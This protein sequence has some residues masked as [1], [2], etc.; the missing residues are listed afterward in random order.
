MRDE[1]AS[2]HAGGDRTASERGAVERT[3]GGR[4]DGKRVGGERAG[5]ER[6]SGEPTGVGRAATDPTGS[7]LFDGARAVPVAAL[8]AAGLVLGIIGD[9]LLR[10]P[11]PPGLNMF[12]WVASIALAAYVLHRRAG[13]ELDGE[14]FAWLAITVLFAAGLA[15]RDSPPLKLL[16]LGCAT[17]GFALAAYRVGAAWVRRAGVFLY[18]RAWGT[19]A[20]HAW[21]APAHALLDASRST[22]RPDIGRT[23]GWRQA[24]AVARGFL[25]ATPLVAVFGALFM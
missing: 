22:A 1:E 14:R 20:L 21:T 7:G 10:A 5:S 4:A 13:L 16:A 25:I 8:L 17:L 11:G 23:A 18:V 2:G 3:G 24:A 12:L 19:G 15:W 9:A 6:A